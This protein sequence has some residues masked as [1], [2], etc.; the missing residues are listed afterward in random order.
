MVLKIMFISINL[1]KRSSIELM[2]MFVC[3]NCGQ[4]FRQGSNKNRE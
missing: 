2:L 4:V 1:F 3:E